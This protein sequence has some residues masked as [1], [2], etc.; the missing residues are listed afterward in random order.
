[1]YRLG[2]A[3][4]ERRNVPELWRPLFEGPDATEP[5]RAL[6]I[7]CGSG[8]DAVHLALGGTLH[9]VGHR[10][11]CWQRDD[12]VAAAFGSQGLVDA[13][14]DALPRRRGRT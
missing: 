5:A 13:A 9:Q 7:G 10:T 12:A 4:W 8:R 6:D 11:G 1:M 3:P 2:F 14:D